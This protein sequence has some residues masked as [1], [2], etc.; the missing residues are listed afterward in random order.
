M[1][2]KTINFMKAIFQKARADL[3]VKLHLLQVYP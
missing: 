2:P 1:R 3:T